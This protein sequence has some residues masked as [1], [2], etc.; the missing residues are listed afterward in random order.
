[1]GTCV[2]SPERAHP[3]TCVAV[4]VHPRGPAR[5]GGPVPTGDAHRAAQQPPAAPAR[6]NRSRTPV[7]LGDR[8]APRSAGA[9]PPDA[10]ERTARSAGPTRID[11]VA[12]TRH[13]EVTGSGGIA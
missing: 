11:H 5:P 6:D 2:R 9:L 8:L 13:Q 7:R 10:A 1:M 4:P 12:T 3:D